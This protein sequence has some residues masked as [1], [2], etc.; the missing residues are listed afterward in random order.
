MMSNG[1]EKG[2]VLLTALMVGLLLALI[3]GVAMNLAMTET[4]E[5]SGHWEETASRLLAES[6]VEQVV[7]WLTHNELPGP[8]GTA[9]IGAASGVPGPELYQFRGTAEAPDLDLDAARPEDDRFL[10]DKSTGAF[11]GLAE[12]GRIARLRLYGPVRPEG[13]CTVEVTGESRRGLRRTSSIELGATRIPPL[14]AAIQAGLSSTTPDVLGNDIGLEGGISPAFP[15]VLA[16]WG[17]LRLAGNPFLGRTAEFPRKSDQATVTGLGYVE[18]GGRSEDRWM[19]AWIGGIPRFEDSDNALP[20]NVH[21]HQDPVPGLLLSHWEYLKFKETAKRF[22]TYYVPDREGR[23]FRNGNK[24]PAL[25]QTPAEV[26]GAPGFGAPRG[27]VFVDTLDQGP[28]TETNMATLVLESPYMEGVFF[29]N[30]HVVLRPEGEGQTIPALS[31]PPDGSRS[32]ALRVP[33]NIA[34]VAIQGVLYTTG[35]IT[36][37][38]PVRVFGAVVAERGLT[39]GGTLEVWYNHD[40][41]RGLVQGL[42]VVFPLRGTWREGES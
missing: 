6:G 21:A 39:G 3:G 42:P 15:R 17:E 11:R 14:R 29:V 20:P 41:G 36:I 2:G 30:A 16:H 34:G 1:T 18:I 35:G 28:P 38:R 37:E 31:P 24:E 5:S 33:V 32:G 26:F 27:L 8:S 9:R 25:A 23:L 19:E 4:A 40:L 13:L 22:G 10:N 7:A 12:L